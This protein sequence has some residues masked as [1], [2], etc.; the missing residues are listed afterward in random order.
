MAQQR[1]LHG[2][3]HFGILSRFVEEIPPEVIH[4][5][6]PQKQTF[7]SFTDAPR[8]K[9]KVVEDYKLPQTYAG[10]RIGQNVRHAKFGTG[11][12]IEAVNKGESAR[13]TINF[14]KAGIKELDTAFAKLEAV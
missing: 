14:G 5:L 3:T 9:N 8:V 2:Q 13:L 11:V 7:N 10:F 1:L 6:S 4:H 12:I